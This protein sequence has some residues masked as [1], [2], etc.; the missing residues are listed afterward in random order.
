MRQKSLNHT[1]KAKSKELLG[2]RPEFRPETNLNKS[3]SASVERRRV[4]N[5]STLDR[6]LS[7]GAEYS[8]RLAQS[9]N[10]KLQQERS[11]PQLT[12]H[13]SLSFYECKNRPTD[14]PIWER[15]FQSQH[16]Y[17]SGKFDRL[18]D[19]VEWT[20][21]PY[22]YT[23]KPDIGHS[24]LKPVSKTPRAKPLKPLN[25]ESTT[26]GG[27][28]LKVEVSVGGSVHKLTVAPGADCEAVADKF[29]FENALDDRLK[30]GLREQLRQN[31]K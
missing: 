22:E 29:A 30:D 14:T 17:F 8:E 1:A 27:K 3:S 2:E 7:K 21:E 11:D 31:I 18:P 15:M 23:F 4:N 5:K 19:A 13:P 10:L 24:R 16:K 20:K 6:L 25:K 26:T 9:R 28:E 12:F